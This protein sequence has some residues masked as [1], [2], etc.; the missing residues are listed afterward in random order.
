MKKTN[1]FLCFFLIISGFINGNVVFSLERIG[2]VITT[3]NRP[4][5]TEKT[6]SYL[7]KTVVDENSILYFVIIDDCST[8]KKT[9]ELVNNFSTK[10]KNIII[11]TIFLKK[12]LGVADALKLGFL[13]LKKNHNPKYYLNLDSDVISKKNWLVKLIELEKKTS[14]NQIYPIIYT[15][16]NSSLHKIMK[17]DDSFLIKESI[18]G[19]NIFFNNKQLPIVLK[20]L[21]KKNLWDWELVDL[22]REKGGLFISTNP[23]YLQHIGRN[24]LNSTNGIVNGS[25]CISDIALDFFE[26]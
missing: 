6:L 18:G 23:S 13:Y 22:V 7:E 10:N 5:Y 25:G 17:Y 8:E 14:C 4:E 16:Y 15:A 3:F 11:K 20:S 9:I 24:G 26:D 19:M 12:N 2:C 1:S 21:H